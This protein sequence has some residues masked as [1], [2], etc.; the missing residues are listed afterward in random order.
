MPRRKDTRP[1]KERLLAKADTSGGE[2]ACWIWRAARHCEFGYGVLAV[3]RVSK[4]AHRLSWEEYR[5]PIP[6]GMC[7]LHSCDNPMC[8][9]P[10]HLFLGTRQDNIRDMVNKGRQRSRGPREKSN[11][12]QTTRMDGDE[13]GQE[14]QH[15]SR[16]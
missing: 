15:P 11:A 9:N 7:V 16:L 10:G 12:N 13:E 1:I 14:G 8:I 5:G 3:N 2:D 6:T 4:R